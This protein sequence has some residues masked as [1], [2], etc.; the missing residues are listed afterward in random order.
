MKNITKE[1]IT[2][3]KRNNEEQKESRVALKKFRIASKLDAELQLFALD[4]K[5]VL[6]PRIPDLRRASIVQDKLP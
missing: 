5:N 2:N 4:M 3:R 1:S 6:I